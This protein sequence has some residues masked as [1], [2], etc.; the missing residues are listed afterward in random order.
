MVPE[1]TRDGGYGSCHWVKHS[2][3]AVVGFSCSPSTNDQLLARGPWVMG[4]MAPGRQA[5]ADAVSVSYC[6]GNWVVRYLMA[7]V[8]LAVPRFTGLETQP[9]RCT[10]PCLTAPDSLSAAVLS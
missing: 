6:S 5:S 9:I 4:R 7:Q 2:D 8:C 10:A 3:T 1:Q